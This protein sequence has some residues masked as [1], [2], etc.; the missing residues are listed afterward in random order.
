MI[1]LGDGTVTA[2]LRN[3]FPEANLWRVCRD[4]Y[5]GRRGH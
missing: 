1:G 3:R 2:S 4:D 5:E